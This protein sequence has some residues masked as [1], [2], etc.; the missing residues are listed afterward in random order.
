MKIGNLVKY[1]EPRIPAYHGTIGIV[2]AFHDRYHELHVRES[3]LVELTDGRQFID[4]SV[5]FEILSAM[6]ES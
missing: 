6:E 1:N 5:C 2:I 3:I 4:H